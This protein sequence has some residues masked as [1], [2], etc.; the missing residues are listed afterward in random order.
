MVYQWK[1]TGINKKVD[2]QAAGE[3]LERISRKCE[4]TPA[5]IVEESVHEN[6]VLHNLFEWN[7][8]KAAKQY[9]EYQ[10]RQI[11]CSIITIEVDGKTTQEPVRAFVKI[12]DSC[13]PLD[14][15]IKI[16][17]YKNEMLHRALGEL[18]SFQK[19]YSALKELT[20]IF[21]SIQIVLDNIS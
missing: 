21:D 15:V 18:K 13:Q 7:D 6:A 16:D 3:E 11:V 8:D 12:Q 10:A 20:N 17:D 5:N 2:A 19:K 14:V 1:E 4:L 9:R